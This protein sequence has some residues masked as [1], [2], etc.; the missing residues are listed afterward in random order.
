MRVWQEYGSIFKNPNLQTM[1]LIQLL[2]FILHTGIIAA[3][4]C[5]FLGP[6]QILPCGVNST[7][8]TADLSQCSAG[9]NPNQTTAWSIGF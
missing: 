6:D 8:L 1:K 3:Q 5:P 4:Y 9:S 7:T 2:I